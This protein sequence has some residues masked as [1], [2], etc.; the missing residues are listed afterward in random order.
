SL[1]SIWF[2]SQPTKTPFSLAWKVNPPAF[3]FTYEQTFIDLP[4]TIQTNL[5]PSLLTPQAN[6]CKPSRPIRSNTVAQP[7]G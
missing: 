1:L 5:W 4:L 6:H 3:S 2:N 7:Q